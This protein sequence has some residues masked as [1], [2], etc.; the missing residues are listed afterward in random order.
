[1]NIH[2]KLRKILI[3]YGNEEY[4]DGII[5][6]ISEL[7]G[8]QKTSCEEPEIVQISLNDLL[9]L[10]NNGCGFYTID[11]NLECGQ[12]IQIERGDVDSVLKFDNEVDTKRFSTIRYDDLD[13]NE[14]LIDSLDKG[15]IECLVDEKKGG[16]V[17]YVLP[18]FDIG[19]IAGIELEEKKTDEEINQIMED[20]RLN[21]YFECRDDEN[22]YP[23]SSIRAI[24]GDMK[25]EKI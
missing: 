16:I 5:D 12:P 13:H 21:Y 14:D 2:D 6:E 7:F 24:L 15:E 23:E 25:N 8:H 20:L 17:A 11:V 3:D 10:A 22:Y 9:K 4:G 1:M 19:L 18:S